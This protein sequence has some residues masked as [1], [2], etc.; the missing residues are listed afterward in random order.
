[1]SAPGV[2]P[3]NQSTPAS[4]R[5]IALGLILIPI[6]CY[7]LVQVELV[8]FSTY[9]TIISLIFTVVFCLFVLI[10]L[11]QLLKRF[12]PQWA[13]GQD[14]LLLIFVMLSVVSATAGC[15]VMEILIPILGH[16]FWFATPEND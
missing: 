7:W 2:D 13:S 5:A 6:N 11:N 12:L 4:W 3:S 15:S 14:E 10:L 8:Q 16:A 9:P 1:M